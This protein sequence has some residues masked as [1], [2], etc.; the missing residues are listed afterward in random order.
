[1]IAAKS[2]RRACAELLVPLSDLESR[3]E[4]NCTALM[5]AAMGSQKGFL[6]RKLVQAGADPWATGPH[7]E[8]A[9]ELSAA[10][11]N[12]DAAAFF[13]N[14]GI[15]LGLD[16]E[17][18][19]SRLARALGAAASRAPGN[20]AAKTVEGLLLAGADPNRDAT[21]GE[22]KPGAESML[23][24][25]LVRGRIDVAAML[26]SHGASVDAPDADG[27][28]PIHALAR[29]GSLTPIE[30]LLSWGADPL[31]RSASGLLAS[32]IAL[33]RGAGERYRVLKAAEDRSRE[34]LELEAVVPTSCA[35]PKP[36][37]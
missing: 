17:E 2:D 33:A 37:L 32:E 20:L 27:E 3:D 29:G 13:A 26:R 30:L 18:W 7:G 28:A 9:M 25:A 8:T 31:A 4:Q 23:A 19:N 6:A 15:K 1:M 5:W 10:D 36:R 14:Y 24:M 16:T 12:A 35:V 21:T 22:S 34:S 11:G